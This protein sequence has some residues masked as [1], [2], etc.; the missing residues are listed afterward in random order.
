MQI[1]KKDIVIINP[2][3]ASVKAGHF[4]NSNPFKAEVV[5]VYENCIVVKKDDT[6]D[7]FDC[8]HSEVQLDLD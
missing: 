7:Y 8:L 4:P 5:A 6:N 3:P 1:E 2:S